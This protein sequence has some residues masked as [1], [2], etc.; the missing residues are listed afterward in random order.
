MEE[1]IAAGIFIGTLI[2]LFTEHWH[3][4]V[5]SGVGASVMVA[6]GLAMDFYDEEHAIEAIEFET[7]GLLMGMMILVSLLQTTGFFEFIAVHVSKMGGG[8]L[9]RLM[10]TLG[11]TTALL[12]MVLDN[13]TTIVLMA[14]MTVLVAEFLGISPI[15]LLISQAIFSNIGGMAT[16]VGDPPNVLIG[17]AAD[18]SFNDFLVNLGPIVAVLLFFTFLMLRYLFRKDLSDDQ[19][20]DARVESVQN[21]SAKEALTDRGNAQRVLL[22]LAGV[23]VLFLMESMLHITPAFAALAGAGIALAWTRHDI[24]EVLQ[25]VEWDVLLFFSGLFVLV[26]GLEATGLLERGAE[27]LYGLQDVSPVLMGL[28]VMWA[29]V[30]L[31]ALVDN[32]PITIA[33]IPIVLS[34]SSRGIDVLPLWWAI[35]LGAGIGGV[36][37]PI[38]ST[39]NVVVISVSERTNNP[40]TDREWLTTGIPVALTATVIATT[41]YIIMFDYLGRG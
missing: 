25:E 9:V 26:G 6:V 17:A 16:L 10:L 39:A 38:G 36:A 21:L 32:V 30:V 28:I 37:T 5:V 34:L 2:L 20:D 14:P 35:A 8:S 33:V 41:L 11:I 40:I 31:S 18:L 15:P 3:R 29:M 12:S 13:V 19:L 24:H 22:V 7:L 1:I 27:I 4:V 23:V